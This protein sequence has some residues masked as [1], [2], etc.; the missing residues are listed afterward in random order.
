[1]NS[2]S[3]RIDVLVVED[4]AA[5][6][7]VTL[8][9]IRRAVPQARVLW[10]A[11]G[12]LA[13]EYLSGVGTA[14]AVLRDLPRLV[15]LAEE[16]KVLSGAFVL[17]VI[18]AH[19]RTSTVQVVMMTQRETSRI[20]VRREF[21][22]DEYIA[23][24][25]DPDEYCDQIMQLMKQRLHRHGISSNTVSSEVMGLPPGQGQNRMRPLAPSAKLS[26]APG[27]LR[28]RRLE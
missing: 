20:V 21:S 27:P 16:M 2:K 22:A 28:Q 9:A 8:F 14:G 15:L 17:D 6:A 13:L 25:D 12:N 7:D 1:M 11:S 18:R 26:R 4:R 24:S 23:R 10:L 3:R 5:D 19:P